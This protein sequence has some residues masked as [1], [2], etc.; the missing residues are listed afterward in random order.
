VAEVAEFRVH[1]VCKLS[2]RPARVPSP[3]RSTASFV[4]A[5]W[6][7]K[8]ERGEA[9]RT[10]FSYKRGGVRVGR[11]INNSACQAVHEEVYNTAAH[12]FEL[13]KPSESRPA[14]ERGKEHGIA[15]TPSNASPAAQRAGVA[16]ANSVRIDL[17]R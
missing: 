5:S 8:L 17:C 6:C 12:A 9:I 13:V 1:A 4:N 3:C 10:Q 16:R 15:T 7:V 14:Q 11:I 2:H